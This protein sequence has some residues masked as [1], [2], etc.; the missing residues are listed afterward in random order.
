MKNLNS[1]N[2]NTHT[3]LDDIIASK[4]NSQRD[5]DYK[6]RVSLLIPNI[7]LLYNNYNIIH[8]TN[9]H[10]SLITHGYL[11]IDKN[12]L[13]KLYSSKNKKLVV[14]KNRATTTLDNR[15]SNVCQYCTINSV[16]TLDHI[17][18]KNEFPEFSV[19]PKNLLPACSEC[20]SYK[21]DNWRFNNQ[22][23]F[24]NLYTDILPQ[25]QYLF[26]DITVNSPDIVVRF[27]LSNMN[28][29]DINLYSLIES[30]FTK[31][32][33]LNRFNLKSNDII[34]ELINSINA[35]KL[36]LNKFDTVELIQAK[37]NA[38]KILFG[39]NYFKSI[40]EETLINNNAFIDSFFV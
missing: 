8:H 36:K 27:R 10:I 20:N 11:N 19:N 26:A 35:S 34:S 13:L 2:G 29:I 23:L 9:N 15:A 12:D 38:D 4:R 25:E 5:P 22:R 14:F 3:F 1:F 30:H 31:L 39:N 28:G 7:K 17:V 16:N 18:P 40:L 32:Y 33:L 37:I 24:L 21:L 6:E